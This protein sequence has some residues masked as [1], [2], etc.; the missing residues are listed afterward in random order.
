M[1]FPFIIRFICRPSHYQATL[2]CCVYPQIAQY[3]LHTSIFKCFMP[4]E[5]S[6]C[7]RISQNPYLTHLPLVY[8]VL[9]TQWLIK[10][11]YWQEKKKIIS[12]FNNISQRSRCLDTFDV[13]SLNATLYLVISKAI[14]IFNIFLL[15]YIK[16]LS[17]DWWWIAAYGNML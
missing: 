5:K 1:F 3:S 14:F 8:Y 6:L 17:Q 2:R 16:F 15:Q 4:K 10:Q 11:S 13:I 7:Y 12:R 9:L